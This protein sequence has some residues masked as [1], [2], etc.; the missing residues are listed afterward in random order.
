MKYLKAFCVA[1]AVLGAAT[2]SNAQTVSVGTAP[3][4]SASYLTG[5]AVAKIMFDKAHLR[6]R[7]IPQGGSQVSINLANKGELDFGIVITPPLV[8]AWH[9]EGSFKSKQ[10]NVRA[11]AILRTLHAGFL[12]RAKSNI[13]SPADFKG[14][15]VASGFT[16]LRVAGL[17]FDAALAASNVDK[18]D[19]TLVPEP[20]GG[21]AV[22]DLVAGRLDLTHF[23]LTSAK[24]REANAQVGIRFVSMPNSPEAL[25]KVN[26]VLPGLFIE[27]VNPSPNIPGITKPTN[28]IAAKYVLMARAGVPDDVVYKVVKALHDNRKALVETYQ[29]MKG[30][31]PNAMYLDFGV[32]YHSGAL[33]Y[34]KQIGLAK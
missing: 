1:W 23:S 30:F 15:R 10:S 32:P 25:A 4:G 33:K 7:A 27:T 18:K 9:G 19:L 11:V 34:Y 12:V 28:V 21:R 20:T 6:A 16:R 26:K 8:Q 22:D 31:D 13:H 2:A 29:G 3:Q 5:S 24:V 14:K 17:M